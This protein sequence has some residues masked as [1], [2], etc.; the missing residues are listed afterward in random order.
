ME[1]LKDIIE[2]WTTE[3]RIALTAYQIDKLISFVDMVYREK[4]RTN[5]TG[6][7]GKVEMLEKLVL[8]SIEPLA[9]LDVPRGTKLVDIGTG[10]GI[11][12]IP[13]GIFFQESRAV[14]VDSNAKKTSFALLAANELDLPNIEII[15]NRAEVLAREPEYRESFDLGL[16][17]AVGNS[18][19]VAELLLP[20][21]KIGGVVFLYSTVSVTTLG[22]KVV[23][24]ITELG[25]EAENLSSEA[26]GSK[27]LGI[28]IRKLRG[29]PGRFPRRFAV[30]K[31][32]SM[33]SITA[34]ELSAAGN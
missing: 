16:S 21:I 10:A 9:F 25:G 6:L 12:G 4:E 8:G 31:R 24:H 18:Y 32:E 22:K 27:I 33:Q 34:D 1:Q 23:Q 15:T 3:R 5:I 2:N 28:V 14:L 30:I 20:L 11:P 7:R 13:A 19:L 26:D 29:T 17:R